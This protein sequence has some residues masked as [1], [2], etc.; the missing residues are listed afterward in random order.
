ME[1]VFKIMK[2]KNKNAKIYFCIIPSMIVLCLFILIS[3]G[4]E[5][6]K[7]DERIKNSYVKNHDDG[8]Y[9][10]ITLGKALESVLDDVKWKTV[11]MSGLDMGCRYAVEVTGTF[12]EVNVL[13][14]YQYYS[15]TGTFLDGSYSLNSIYVEGTGVS[16]TAYYDLM[17]MA[18]ANFGYEEGYFG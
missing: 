10:E 18:M 15:E 14:R 1:R 5:F 16:D 11:S 7:L 12:E 2:T 13:I 4:S 8:I 6:D 17:S 9:T 3:C